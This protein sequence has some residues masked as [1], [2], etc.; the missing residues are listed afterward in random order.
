[1]LY[2]QHGNVIGENPQ[3]EELIKGAQNFIKSSATSSRASSYGDFGDMP[4]YFLHPAS[5]G[6]LSFNELR[7]LYETSPAVRPAVDSI[8]REIYG[9]PWLVLYDDFEYHGGQVEKL[10]TQWF[11]RVNFD[12]EDIGTVL[13]QFLNDLLVI[14]KGVIE[15]VRNPF[16]QLIELKA[17][18]AA[19]F[20]PVVDEATGMLNAYKEMYPVSSHKQAKI[21]SKDDI[22]FKNYATITY[23][24]SPVPIIETVVNE[25]SLLMLTTK[26][27]AGAFSSDD[28]PPGVLHLGTIGDE[29]RERAKASFA[30]TRSIAQKGNN[31]KIVDNVDKVHWIAFTHPF[32][33]MQMA[34][35]LPMIE[36][37]VARNFGLSQ[38]AAGLEGGGKTNATLGKEASRATM[39]LP[40]TKLITTFLNN[41]VLSEVAPR[42]RFH[43]VNTDST[44]EHSKDLQAQVRI[45]LI[46]INEARLSSG[47]K[48]VK[49]G[50]Q[51][52]V[53]LGNEFVP[54]DKKTGL[55]IY[56]LDIA[57][58][59]RPSAAP[60]PADPPPTETQPEKNPSESEEKP[61]EPVE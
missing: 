19:N 29:A 9:N 48:P 26:N 41:E 2:D 20:F 40:L 6:H 14:G 27:I 18:N 57:G 13:S 47:R 3:T 42:A 44:I 52:F 37:I 50:D 33:E 5:F 24:L 60:P 39:F 31:L 34:E 43:F 10:L 46:T 7:N 45:G 56:R 32:R 12:N 11:N 16:G 17:A 55:P 58:P 54:L 8:T 15:K 23:S 30:E 1:M 38:V 25:I 49:G 22:I 53:L 35:L 59:G 21:H 61:Q 4:M 51:R 28:I 36:R